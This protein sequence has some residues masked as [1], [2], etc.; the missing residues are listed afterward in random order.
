MVVHYALP[1][2]WL[3]YDRSDIIAELTE[4]KA[5][6]LA[7]TAMP[8]QRAWAER[9]Q[10]IELKRE[11]AGTSKIE[12]AEFT[13]R[14]FDEAVA[15][16]APK[17]D[18]TRS[19]RQA[20]AAMHAYRWIEA[21]PIDRPITEDLIKEIHRHI[22]TDCDDDHCPP[23]RLRGAEQNVVFGRPRHRGAVGGS[24]CETAFRK[25]L[26]AV[27]GEFGGHDPL[28]Q[29]LALHYHLGAMHPFLDGNGRT[30]R[31]VEALLLQRS[32][33]K[34]TIFIAMSNYYYD[35]K[36]RYLATLSAVG[37]NGHDMTAFIKF[38][39]VGIAAQCKR[40]LKEIKRHISISLFR[41]VMARMYGR[42]QST[43]KRALAKRQVA[44]LE[45][46]LERDEPCDL[47]ELRTSTKSDYEGLRFP[48][49]AFVRD[50]DQLFALRA[51]DAKMK[52]STQD[53]ETIE[54]FLVFSRLEWATEITET[55]FFEKISKLPA[56]KTRFLR[57]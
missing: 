30:A 1:D 56:A 2:Q 17:D 12:G 43:K 27:N 49:R 33:L 53:P 20:R 8:Y 45:S 39:L 16:E 54:E 28:V 21:L 23:G 3:R 50:L 26:A 15:P 4:A 40:M 7:L 29:A 52:T 10:E 19:Q 35:E 13:D 22:V 38:G 24:E 48:D 9:L 51:I 57:S 5:A 37:S 6:I 11:V 44:L 34:D 14:E 31:A 46:L 32:G 47:A 18:M 42:L 41:D 36:G 55:A 25:L